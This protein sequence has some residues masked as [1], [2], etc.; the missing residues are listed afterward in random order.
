MSSAK[1]PSDNGQSSGYSVSTSTSPNAAAHEPERYAATAAEAVDEALNDIDLEL[2]AGFRIES[3]ELLDIAEQQLLE[4]ERDAHNLDAVNAV[5][6]AFHTVKGNAGFLVVDPLIRSLAHDAE[7]V[8]VRV[9]EGALVLEGQTFDLVLESNSILQSLISSVCQTVDPDEHKE[10][11]TRTERLRE[12]L[13]H[14]ASLEGNSTETKTKLNQVIASDKDT[15][16]PDANNPIAVPTDDFFES[17][18]EASSNRS[19]SPV[20]EDK[21]QEPRRNEPPSRNRPAVTETNETLRV[22]RARLDSLVELVGELVIAESMAQQDALGSNKGT[23]DRTLQARNLAQLSRITRTLQELSLSLRMIPVRATFQKMTRIARDL[24]RK[25]GKDVEFVVEGEHTELDK[26][27]VDEIADPLM[28]MVR[29]AIDHGIEKTAED[30]IAAGKSPVGRVVLKAFHQGGEINI[31]IRDDGKGLDVSKLLAKA[32]E[33]K[34]I[35]EDAVLT[36][37]QTLELIFAPGFSTA[38][39]VTDVSGRG[40]GMDVVRRNIQALRG[41]V[42][43]STVLGQGSCFKIRLPLTLAIIN[44]LIVRKGSHRFVIPTLSVTEMKQL[45]GSQVSNITG[46]AQ[47]LTVRDQHIPL[48]QLDEVLG[49]PFTSAQTDPEKSIVVIVQDGIQCAAI[50]V[51]EV[52][53]QQQIVIKQLGHILN[54]TPGI[55]GG[56]IMPDGQIGI[57]LDIQG[58]I[59]Q[60]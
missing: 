1:N 15:N 42:D 19:P 47:V 27:V 26:T 31:E 29:N 55:A 40:V 11:S 44:G 12:S 23:I 46:K 58:I 7:N 30:R 20:E 45:S 5:F 38:E 39:K 18:P 9:R 34:I 13:R 33:K 50:T 16:R 53:G 52:L 48:I 56:S 60:V 10:I 22:D 43:I 25:L 57:I 36:E 4:L 14:V 35:A 59:S 32:K 21:P 28:H 54:N 2:L 37:Q 8:L 51:D 49:L 24:T 6:R 3:S 41:S 17:V